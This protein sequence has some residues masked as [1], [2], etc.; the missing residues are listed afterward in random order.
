MLRA[1][2]AGR[3]G[4]AWGETLTAKIG[5]YMLMYVSWPS[6]YMEAAVGGVA[7]LK[8]GEGA[9]KSSPLRLPGEGRH[10]EEGLRWRG[11]GRARYLVETILFVAQIVLEKSI[12]GAAFGA[13]K[14][15][16]GQE[17]SVFVDE[18]GASCCRIVVHAITE[19]AVDD[20]CS[21]EAV[22]GIRRQELACPGIDEAH[23][24]VA[25]GA[26]LIAHQR[27]RS[28]RLQVEDDDSSVVDQMGIALGCL[29]VGGIIQIWQFVDRLTDMIVAVEVFVGGLATLGPSR[30]GID[31]VA[32]SVVADRVSGGAGDFITAYV[33]VCD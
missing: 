11:R 14:C 15:L 17:T 27:D 10:R 8:D 28:R 31:L 4:G 9:K 7:C 3:R 19:D 18:E 12:F 1:V 26:K 2:A 25:L 6:F 22:K 21:Q 33:A 16:L 30:E 13:G 24:P 20:M 32:L 29:V 5:I 23:A